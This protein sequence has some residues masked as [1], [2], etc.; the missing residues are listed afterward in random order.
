MDVAADAGL[1]A[2][3]N[4]SIPYSQ[5]PKPG[6]KATESSPTAVGNPHPTLF[7]P[8]ALF[9]TQH[10]GALI[11]RE[12]GEFC[13]GSDS[14]TLAWLWVQ[15]CGFRTRVRLADSRVKPEEKREFRSFHVLEPQTPTHSSLRFVCQPLGDQIAARVFKSKLIPK[16]RHEPSLSHLDRSQELVN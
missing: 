13:F 16:P 2:R 7:P 11:N 10:G 6:G 5:I 15:Y 8:F 14:W 3:V 1:A 9:Q 4:P 12:P